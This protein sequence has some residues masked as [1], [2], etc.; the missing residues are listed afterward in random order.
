MRRLH[1]DGRLRHGLSLQ[2]LP[3]LA[4]LLALRG[5]FLRSGQWHAS[6]AV[7]PPCGTPVC[8]KLTLTQTLTLIVYR[9]RASPMWRHL[10]ESAAV[11]SPRGSLAYTA[12]SLPIFHTRQLFLANQE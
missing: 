11:T 10:H 5:G 2:G 7:T 3:V 6:T 8:V 1:V 4:R 9:K 12:T